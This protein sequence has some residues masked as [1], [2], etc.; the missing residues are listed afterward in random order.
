M[1]CVMSDPDRP[2]FSLRPASHLWHVGLDPDCD[3]AVD[4]LVVAVDSIELP[5]GSCSPGIEMVPPSW[6]HLALDVSERGTE[7][8]L[9][10]SPSSFDLAITE[11]RA[12][13][14]SIQAVLSPPELLSGLR[15]CFSPLHQE[16]PHSVPTMT[17]GYATELVGEDQ[18]EIV[19]ASYREHL[20]GTTV[21]VHR[22]EHRVS[23]P[24]GVFRFHRLGHWKLER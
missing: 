12:S 9:E 16:A 19:L 3:R 18:V 15:S 11:V 20:V 8:N 13:P 22:V 21:P 6:L 2:V 5:M 7:W 10:G 14:Y 1:L 4:T 23:G 17:L 24:Y